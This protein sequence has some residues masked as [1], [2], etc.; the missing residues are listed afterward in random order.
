MPR[1]LTKARAEAFTLST[2]LESSA[3]KEN[4]IQGFLNY[5]W[6]LKMSSLFKALIML[7]PF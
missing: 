2:W 6:L 3:A 5:N 4:S 7:L 1:Y